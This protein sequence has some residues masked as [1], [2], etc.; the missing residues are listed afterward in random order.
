MK[1]YE[2]RNE[3]GTTTL[4]MV[5]RPQPVPA[6]GEVLVR[7]RA[8]SLNFRDL[9]ISKAPRSAPLIPLCDGSGEVVAT[10]PGVTR[11]GVGDRVA[12][13]YF[14]VW[15]SG[16]LRPDV[17]RSFLGQTVDGVLAEYVAL[18]EHG[19]VRVPEHLSFEE[20]ATLP[21]AGLTA[22]QALVTEGRIKAGDTVV[23]M[24][25]GGVSIFALQFALLCGARVIAT[26]GTDSK[27]DRLRALG[28]VAVINYKTT[29]DWDKRVLELTDGI[30][31]DHVVEVG[32]AGTLPRSLRAVRHGGFISLIG[33]LGGAGEKF[34]PGN[35]I[36]KGVR[37]QGIFV[38]STEMFEDMNR[39]IALAAMRPVIDRTYQF[40]EAAQA[41]AFL[42]SGRHFGKICIRV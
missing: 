8:A 31:A 27:I 4:S 3:S 21:C 11:V 23:V 42:E 9:L 38:G 13:T 26:T 28:A 16:P 37:L 17:F 32:G 15:V 36:L 7:M 25:T 22:W 24:G 39:A 35:I 1:A 12:G 41:L 34:S 14:Q 19:V 30:G 2:L 20:A 40:D 5:E 10:G 33:V 6:R 29:P 18:K